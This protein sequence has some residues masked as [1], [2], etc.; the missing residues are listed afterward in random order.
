MLI[1]ILGRKKKKKKVC[2]NKTRPGW[3][4]LQTAWT[5]IRYGGWWSL[6]AAGELDDP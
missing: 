1:I 2:D 3:M 5:S 6:P 4:S